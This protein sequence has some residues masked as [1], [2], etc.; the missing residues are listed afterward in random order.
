MRASAYGDG[1][2]FKF[3]RANRDSAGE[4]GGE[5]SDGGGVVDFGDGEGGVAT[6]DGAGFP[7]EVSGL[8]G[9]EAAIAAAMRE[10]AAG[11]LGERTSFDA[12]SVEDEEEAVE[13]AEEE[14]EG[15]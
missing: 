13:E 12:A 6:L 15:D 7:G 3:K 9:E 5:E 14:E 1:A 2:A 11:V 8:E 4:V 10:V